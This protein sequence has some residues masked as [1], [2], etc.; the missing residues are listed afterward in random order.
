MGGRKGA[1]GVLE[2][3]KD[4]EARDESRAWV[5]LLEGDVHAALVTFLVQSGVMFLIRSL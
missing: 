5:S 3:Y 1:P 2:G 4:E